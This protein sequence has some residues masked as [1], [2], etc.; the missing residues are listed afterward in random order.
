MNIKSLLGIVSV[1][2]LAAC[3]ST[4]VKPAVVQ[5][6]P[7]IE[8]V[9]P[10]TMSG[11]NWSVTL[12]NDAWHQVNVANDQTANVLAA[13]INRSANRQLL[14]MSHPNEKPMN[15]EE[16]AVVFLSDLPDHGV[17]LVSARKV[18]IN[19]NQFISA[20]TFGTNKDNQRTDVYVWILDKNDTAYAFI[21]GGVAASDLAATCNS[22]AATLNIQ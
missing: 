9:S 15:T 19:G 22:I 16:L 10:V 3:A 4:V 8:V 12:P 2:L 7:P 13:A 11:Q 18:T 17:S 21:C 6:S 1:S 14:L 5:S 20:I